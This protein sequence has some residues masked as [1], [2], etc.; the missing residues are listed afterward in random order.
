MYLDSYKETLALGA[1]M[2]IHILSKA[3]EAMFMG[4]KRLHVLR[5]MVFKAGGFWAHLVE[6]LLRYYSDGTSCLCGLL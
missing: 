2:I 5:D 6:H 1:L 3:L 4:C